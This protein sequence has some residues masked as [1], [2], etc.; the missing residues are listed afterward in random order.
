[1][2]LNCLILNDLIGI[3]FDC[4]VQRYCGVSFEVP[5]NMGKDKGSPRTCA[6]GWCT[7]R[8]NLE[9]RSFDADLHTGFGSFFLEI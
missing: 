5:S 2:K 6:D 4:T 9:T 7:K 8:L 1:M 3:C